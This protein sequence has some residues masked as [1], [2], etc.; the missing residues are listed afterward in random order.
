MIT[1]EALERQASIRIA[2]IDDDE[3]SRE[4]IKTITE[5]TLSEQNQNCFVKTYASAIDLLMDLENGV[6]YGAFLVDV[7][8]PKMTGLELARKIQKYYADATIIFVTDYV[9][10]SPGA[11]EVN[12]FR[13]IMKRDLHEKL[14]MA[15]KKMI[16]RLENKATGCYIIRHYLDAEVLLYREIFY[17]KKEGKNVVFCHT[18][19]ESSERKSLIKIAE[20]L[21]QGQFVEVS[22]GYLVNA[23]YVM[24]LKNKELIMRNGDR[25]PVARK[26]IEDILER[27]AAYWN[28]EK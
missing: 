12:A 8:M 13:Y 17:I 26:N 19:G 6:Y 10:Y 1:E 15:L 21:P 20:E 27:I 14:P 18:H 28:S 7:E 5:K 9:Q 16:H 25:I 2:I 4:Q 22:R 3:N 11:F 24:A 23:S